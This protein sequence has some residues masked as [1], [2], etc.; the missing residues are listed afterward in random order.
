MPSIE[1]YEEIYIDRKFICYYLGINWLRESLQ[2]QYQT[3]LLRD[4]H[5]PTI[6]MITL[7]IIYPSEIIDILLV[8]GECQINYHEVNLSE[9]LSRKRTTELFCNPEPRTKNSTR[10]FDSFT[11]STD[12][13]QHAGNDEF[14]RIGNEFFYPIDPYRINC[15]IADQTIIELL[16]GY[17]SRLYYRLNA[18]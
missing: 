3:S 13:S 14:C 2:Y 4:L 8:L 6:L 5:L 12:Y 7:I 17:W 16:R 1:I 18:H 10:P 11:P 9:S 15:I